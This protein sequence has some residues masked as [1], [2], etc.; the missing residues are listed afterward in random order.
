M[1][2]ELYK[3]YMLGWKLGGY[4]KSWDLNFYNENHKIAFTMGISDYIIGDDV[5]SFDNQ[6]KKQIIKRIKKIIS[7]NSINI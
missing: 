2:E 6:T 3:V 5:E 7:E 4:I 1:E